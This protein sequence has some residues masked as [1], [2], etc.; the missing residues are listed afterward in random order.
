M[1]KDGGWFGGKLD[2]KLA[3]RSLDYTVLDEEMYNELVEAMQ[4]TGFFGADAWYANHARNRAYSLEKWKN[5]GDLHM[6]VLFI[7]AKFDATCATTLTRLCEPM[8]QHCTNLTEVSIDAGHWV[9]E[10]KPAETSAAIARWLVER[11]K[12]VWPGYWSNGHVHNKQ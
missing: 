1:S 12:D 3:E 7:H 5:D 4:R 2:P 11:C 6:P 9:A 8:R 10:E